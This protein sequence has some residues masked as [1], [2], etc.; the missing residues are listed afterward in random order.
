MPDWL[1]NILIQYP[2]V[3]VIGFVAWYAYKQVREANVERGADS[4]KV[5]E[6]ALAEAKTAHAAHVADLKDLYVRFSAGLSADLKRLEKKIESL[7]R[8]LE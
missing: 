5:Y 4:Q 1:I 2:I 7:S 8:K 6:R 3:V